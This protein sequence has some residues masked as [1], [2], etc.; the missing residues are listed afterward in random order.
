FAHLGV[1]DLEELSKKYPEL[2]KDQKDV[3][4]EMIAG[5]SRAICSLIPDFE[6][7][8]IDQIIITGGVAN[9]TLLVESMKRD[10]TALNIGISV[11]PGE[12]EMEAL[13]DGV[14]RVLSG[15]ERVKEY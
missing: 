14:L 8:Q 10:L 13:R 1:K 15:Q 12:K 11:Y 6:G 9:W 2:S 3:V 4:D 7:E 5:N